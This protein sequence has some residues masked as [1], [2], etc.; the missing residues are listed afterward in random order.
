[1]DAITKDSVA[2]SWNK[3]THSGGSP[4][5]G[6]IVERK[7]PNDKDFVP[8]NRTPINDT[9]FTV[10]GLNEGDEY[11]FRVR[12][13]NDAGESE[14]SKAVGPVKVEAQPEKPTVDMGKIKDITVK[15]GETFDIRV[16]YHGYPQ[17][18]AEW[19]RVDPLGNPKV[20]LLLGLITVLILKIM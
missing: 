20:E 11:Q 8:V 14:P 7:G 13:V 1:M 10:P 3:P 4:I 2:L 5:S 15:A 17:P 19:V 18:V 6:Y 16:P 9:K 12:A